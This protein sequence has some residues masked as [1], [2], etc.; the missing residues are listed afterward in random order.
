MTVRTGARPEVVGLATVQSGMVYVLYDRVLDKS[1]ALN[2]R[3]A[4]VLGFVMAHEIGHVL[5]AGRGHGHVG[6]MKP[7]LDSDVLRTGLIGFT[8]EEGREMRVT[9]SSGDHAP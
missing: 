9:I 8:R 3:I 6:V 5:L 4:R 1:E 2:V 7:R